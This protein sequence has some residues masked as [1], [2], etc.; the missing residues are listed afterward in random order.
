MKRIIIPYNK[1]LISLARKHRNNSTKSEIILWGHLKGKQILAFDFHRQK[2]LGNYI[3]GFFCNEL[4][5]AI[6]LDGLSHTIEE[7]V[8]KD[9]IKEEF[10]N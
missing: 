7:V 6:E 9:E 5:L 3:V 10:I 4:L 2:P 1:K 8:E